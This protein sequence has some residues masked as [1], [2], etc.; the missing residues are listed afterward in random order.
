MEA[1][2]IRP[3]RT[4]TDGYVQLKRAKNSA[5][6]RRQETFV[7][8]EVWPAAAQDMKIAAGREL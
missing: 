6:A 3:H 4:R 1:C 5:T 7:Q 2:W 8:V